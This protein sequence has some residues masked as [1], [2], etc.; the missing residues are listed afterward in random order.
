[1]EKN[2]SKLNSEGKS[3]PS[4]RDGKF[5]V[6]GCHHLLDDQNQEVF[7]LETLNRSKIINTRHR[8]IPTLPRCRCPHCFLSVR[9]ETDTQSLGG[10]RLFPQIVLLIL[11]TDVTTDWFHLRLLS[12]PPPLVLQSGPLCSSAYPLSTRTPCW[13]SVP[14][15][16]TDM[17]SAWHHFSRWRVFL[18]PS[19]S[20]FCFGII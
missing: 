10:V 7:I 16:T 14:S 11:H 19:S 3:C 2:V 8:L 6:L 18:P 1:M 15:L 4:F 17:G 20:R 12:A 5:W 9:K 13:M